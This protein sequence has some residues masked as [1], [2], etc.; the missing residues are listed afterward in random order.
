M[1]EVENVTLINSL[2]INWLSVE[3]VVCTAKLSDDILSL[4]LVEVVISGKL[5]DIT[6]AMCTEIV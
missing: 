2:I 1:Y 4:C 3:E 6:M 5:S